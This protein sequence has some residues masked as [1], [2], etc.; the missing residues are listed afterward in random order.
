[1]VPPSCTSNFAS[2]ILNMTRANLLFLNQPLTIYNRFTP[3][4]RTVKHSPANHRIEYSR[5]YTP[6][7]DAR[8]STGR[9]M[10]LVLLR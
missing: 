10:L 5:G 8:N 1:M 7:G 3:S 4:W 6:N 2:V 9:L